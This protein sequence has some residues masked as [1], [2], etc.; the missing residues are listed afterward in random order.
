MPG[1]GLSNFLSQNKCRVGKVCKNRYLAV[2]LSNLL[3]QNKCWV[4]KVCKNRCP[5]VDLSNFQLFNFH[6]YLYNYITLPIS[7]RS[8]LTFIILTLKVSK[9][10]SK[11]TIHCYSLLLSPI[12][13][14]W[15]F[16]FYSYNLYW[17][18][19]FRV[20]SLG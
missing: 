5:A 12:L 18:C 17:A 19:K 4:G 14:F 13:L 9:F 7:G 16:Q 15:S 10:T 2:D 6:T 8:F 11:I 20:L 1:S 3:S